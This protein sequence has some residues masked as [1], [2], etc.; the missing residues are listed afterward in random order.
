MTF[1]NLHM[2]ISAYLWPILVNDAKTH[3]VRAGRC[4]RAGRKGRDDMSKTGVCIVG[5]GHTAFG[6]LDGRTL[7][8]LIVEAAR[9]DAER[10]TLSFWAT[11]IRG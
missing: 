10:M 9:I 1:I 4:H 8:E 2:A 6:R 5:S 7:E 11:S 3:T